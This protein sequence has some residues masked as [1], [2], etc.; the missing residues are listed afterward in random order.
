MDSE[1]TNLVMDDPTVQ[2]SGAEDADFEEL[3]CTA[4]DVLVI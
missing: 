3:G 4:E 2:S 1:I